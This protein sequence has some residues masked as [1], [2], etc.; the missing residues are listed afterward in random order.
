MSAT[1]SSMDTGTAVWAAKWAIRST[2]P[3]RATAEL[4]ELGTKLVVETTVA[5][6]RRE[7]QAPR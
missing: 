4:G 5:A 1:G 7:T 6:I 3:K 2:G